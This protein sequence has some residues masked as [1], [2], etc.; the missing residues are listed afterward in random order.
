M[1]DIEDLGSAI[2]IKLQDTRNYKS[3][4]FI[5]VEKFYLEIC[6]KYI[7]VRKD[8]KI[9]RFLLKYHNG[10]CANMVMGKT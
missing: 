7:S 10:K 1:G 3:R 9:S 4:S 5:I 8:I 6:R 2:L